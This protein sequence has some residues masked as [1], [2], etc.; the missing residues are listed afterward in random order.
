MK[1]AIKIP[2]RAGLREITVIEALE[3]LLQ[4]MVGTN[5]SIK[6]ID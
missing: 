4:T 3:N 5:Y 1:I 2:A 6:E